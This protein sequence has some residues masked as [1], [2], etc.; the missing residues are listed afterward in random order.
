[1]VYAAHSGRCAGVS[2]AFF[3]IKNS[4]SDL[5]CYRCDGVPYL[6]LWHFGF[7]Y[8]TVYVT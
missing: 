1:M 5:S 3:D 2:A 6:R 7:Y 8:G 4:C